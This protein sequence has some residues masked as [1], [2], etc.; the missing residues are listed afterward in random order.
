MA[1]LPSPDD[2][3]RRVMPAATPD[4]NARGLDYSPVAQAGRAIGEGVAS[5]GKA[6]SAYAV[7][8]RDQQNEVD[9]FDTRKRLID[10]QLETEMALEERKRSM[11]VGGTGYTEAWAAELKDRAV[12]F[13]G[14]KDEN[15]PPAQR[16]KVGM[17]LAM[18]RAQMLERAQ[19]DEFA[20]KDRATIAGLETTVTT[21]KS[22]VAAEPTKHDEV[23]GEITSL[24]DMSPITP[25]QRDVY[26]RKVRQEVQEEAASA[27]ADRATTAEGREAARK[28][29]APHM[30]DRAEPSSGG[31][32][33]KSY[34]DQIKKFEGFTAQS[35][36]DYKQHSI[37]YG[38]RGKPGEVIDKAEAD[39]RLNEELGKAA[40][41]VDQ[42]APGIDGGTRAALISLT[43]NAG[44][45]W[46][47]AGLGQAIKSGDLATAKQRFLQYNQAGGAV[48][49]GLASRRQ[50]EASWFGKGDTPQGA[51]DG[52][53][54]DAGTEVYAGPFA[55]LPLAKRRA[56]FARAES[57][58]NRTK[59]EVE[60]AIREQMK[61]S[62]KGVV[63]PEAWLSAI[64]PKI[65]A[66]NNPETTALYATMLGKAERTARLKAVPPAILTPHAEELRAKIN[67]QGGT[68]EELEYVEHVEK[69][70]K[71]SAAK[72]AENS[73]GWA[74]SNRIVVPLNDGKPPADIEPG[75]RGQWE[76]MYRGALDLVRQGKADEAMVRYPGMF[77]QVEFK[78]LNFN[79]PDIDTQL[80]QRLTDAKGVAR[81]AET[82]IQ[83]FTPV[84]REAL[85]QSLV[86]GGDSLLFTMSKI[87]AAA[88]RNGVDAARVLKEISSKDA[89]ELTML[90]HLATNAGDPT[91]MKV[92][93]KAMAWRHGQGENFKSTIDKTQA[94]PSLG[95]YAEVFK[96]APEFR[97]SAQSLINIIYEHEAR[98]KGH[99]NF[100]QPLYTEITKRVFGETKDRDGNAYGGIGYQGAGWFD[101]KSATRVLVPPQVKQSEFDTLIETIR[102][103]DLIKMGGVPKDPR[104]NPYAMSEIRKM[105]WS[106]VNPVGGPPTPGIYALKVKDLPSGPLY[107]MDDAGRPIVV[108][109]RPVIGDLQKRKPSI[110]MGYDGVAK[111]EAASRQEYPGYMTGP[112]PAAE[113]EAERPRRSTMPIGAFREGAPADDA[114]VVVRVENEPQPSP[115]PDDRQYI[116]INGKTTYFDDPPADPAPQTKRV[117][118]IKRQD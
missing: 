34:I 62:E 7:N 25:A 117:E 106:S 10:W 8:L 18:F 27:W 49:P 100:N 30:A 67:A 81:Y 1:R 19:R 68:K 98:A 55:D 103:D 113:P 58:F 69:L 47:R 24:I 102:P 95:E 60:G 107:A 21:L 44:D 104:G 16:A 53:Y 87:T 92:A 33:G 41:I 90:G 65:K 46:T 63:P 13:T 71:E 39:R 108:D 89:P 59:E 72:V 54:M 66:L 5:I 83:M 75:K 51:P 2:M 70:A 110:F 29:L 82:D 97:D 4:V 114:E 3:Q 45:D 6:G 9:D 74:Q 43:F 15:I 40:A 86:K 42:F 101:G 36:W 96:V 52:G 57:T 91:I 35:K 38:T 112:K 99:E 115:A 85:T 56:I 79:A 80:D 116:T 77:K 14:E 73:I 105:E 50:Q 22:R 76:Q 11:P 37:G 109:L 118:R 31:P 48:L 32:I 88:E 64:E 20:E 28:L 84:E 111:D 94:K 78:A 93:A 17:R 12:S 23:Q 61:V 26:K